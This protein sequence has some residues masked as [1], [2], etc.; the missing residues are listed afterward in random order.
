[1]SICVLCIISLRRILCNWH[2]FSWCFCVFTHEL[3]MYRLKMYSC[4]L[5]LSLIIYILSHKCAY[6]EI[7]ESISSMNDGLQSDDESAVLEPIP[8]TFDYRFNVTQDQNNGKPWHFGRQIVNCV[9]PAKCERLQNSTCFGSKI[10]YKFT[11]LALTDATSQADSRAQLH[12]YEA[13]RN[14]PKCWAVIQ[15]MFTQQFSD[16]ANQ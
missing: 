5:L 11:S 8:H 12:M 1:M 13:L 7:S 4:R 2:L 14:I 10:P 9:R 16:R 6:A 15:V 3:K